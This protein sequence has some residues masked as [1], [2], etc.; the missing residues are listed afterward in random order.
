L[1]IDI[2]AEPLAQ[3]TS[4]AL[5]AYAFEGSPASSGM[6]ERLPEETRN[7]LSEMCAAGELTGK[8]FEC[9]LIHRP[10]GLAASRL[11]VVGAG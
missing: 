1:K 9:T 10:A 6:V 2:A 7:L 4:P 8:A 5:V 11:L 3:L